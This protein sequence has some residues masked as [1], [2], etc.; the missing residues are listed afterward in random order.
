M[1]AFEGLC[2][3]ASFGPPGT[4]KRKGGEKTLQ[5]LPFPPRYI[6]EAISLS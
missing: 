2:F 4:G 3:L 6:V 1:E 5:S